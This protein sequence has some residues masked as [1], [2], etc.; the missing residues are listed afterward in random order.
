MAVIF[1][2]TLAASGSMSLAILMWVAYWILNI[3][4]TIL[5]IRKEKFYVGNFILPFLFFMLHLSYGLGTIIGILNGLTIK[6]SKNRII[7]TE[8]EQ[9]KK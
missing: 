7:K 2:T 8:I 1:T 4:M 9:I 3:L 6:K 5:S